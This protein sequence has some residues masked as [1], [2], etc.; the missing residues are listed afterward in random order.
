MSLTR[1]L[2]DQAEDGVPRMITLHDHDDWLSGLH[3]NQLWGLFV[4]WAEYFTTFKA[5]N[6]PSQGYEVEGWMIDRLFHDPSKDWW[7]FRNFLLD[8]GEYSDGPFFDEPIK[9][10]LMKTPYIQQQ[11]IS[12]VI[13]FGEN[14]LSSKDSTEISN[15]RLRAV[16][17]VAI[18]E[19]VEWYNSNVTAL[20]VVDSVK[21]LTLIANR[22]I[23]SL[24]PVQDTDPDEEMD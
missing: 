20:E 13:D 12:A 10:L 23:E 15:E 19:W 18:S 7:L 14:L 16:T 3:P 1:V 5:D 8:V 22:L 11:V 21:E 2:H 4:M 24:N 9:T 6:I 17:M